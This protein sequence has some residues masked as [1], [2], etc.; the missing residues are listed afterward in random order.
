MHPDRVLEQVVFPFLNQKL[1]FS[2]EAEQHRVIHTHLDS[3]LA[4]FR[5]AKEDPT[6]FNAPLL[7]ERMIA[8][9][10]PLVQV[11]LCFLVCNR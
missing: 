8:F 10:E 9:R 1:D 11:A 2:S 6:T 5:K 4:S 3:L 7:K